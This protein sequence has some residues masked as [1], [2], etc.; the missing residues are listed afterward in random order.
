MPKFIFRGISI[1][2]KQYKFHIFYNEIT[3]I[4][5]YGFI[6][7]YSV[8]KFVFCNLSTLW[9]WLIKFDKTTIYWK[10]LYKMKLVISPI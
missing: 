4:S 6:L 9:V 2:V 8:F 1:V 10:F 3:E 7:I 5:P